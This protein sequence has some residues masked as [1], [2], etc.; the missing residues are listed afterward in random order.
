MEE[1]QIFTFRE[2]YDPTE[3]YERCMQNPMKDVQKIL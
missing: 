3:S 2:S 1:A